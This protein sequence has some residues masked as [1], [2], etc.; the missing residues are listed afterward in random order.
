MLWT[1][2]LVSRINTPRTFDVMSRQRSNAPRPPSIRP[3]RGPRH[4]PRRAGGR[5]LWV[6][7]AG[8]LLAG[9]ATAAPP[10]GVSL[11]PTA[12]GDVTTQSLSPLEPATAPTAPVYPAIHDMP[13]PTG[14]PTLSDYEQR[15]LQQDLI[16]IRKRLERPNAD[17]EKSRP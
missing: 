10:P 11:A 6:A 1:Y 8:L 7:A 15:K 4:A 5:V 14:E 2:Y 17:T 16:A 12:D 9:C 3:P 13:P